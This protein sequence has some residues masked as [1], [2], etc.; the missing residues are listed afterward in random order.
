M[1]IDHVP[2]D[3]RKMLEREQAVGDPRFDIL[4]IDAFVRMQ[5]HHLATLE[6]FS[7][8]SSGRGWRFG[9]ACQ[10]LACG[11]AAVVQGGGSSGVHPYG[12]VGVAE[13]ASRPMPWVFMTRHHTVTSFRAKCRCARSWGRV[14]DIVVPA[15]ERGSLLPLLRR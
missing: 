6:A 13:N 15:D 14:R 3:A 5:Y 4:M 9:D 8:I 10:Q 1:R 12:V 2:G 7:S 11:P